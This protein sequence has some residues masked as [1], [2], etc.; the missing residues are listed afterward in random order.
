MIGDIKIGS[1]IFPTDVSIGEGKY[2]FP[3]TILTFSNQYK[4]SHLDVLLSLKNYQCLFVE[5]FWQ[6]LVQKTRTN[7]Q[8]MTF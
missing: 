5:R 8:N 3:T 6:C 7:L 2:G 1:P 4:S